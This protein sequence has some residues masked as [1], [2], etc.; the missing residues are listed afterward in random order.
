MKAAAILPVW[1]LGGSG[2]GRERV[3]KMCV[4]GSSGYDIILQR[5]DGGEGG[6]WVQKRE[7]GVCE[8]NRKIDK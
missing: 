7:R 2:R 4:G 8:M 6:G 3:G 5:E 1:V